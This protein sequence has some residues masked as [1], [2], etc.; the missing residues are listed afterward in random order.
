[1]KMHDMSLVASVEA[2]TVPEPRRLLVRPWEDPVLDHQGHDPRSSY[3]ET[4]WLPLLG[5]SATLLA[6][7]LASGLELD[8]GG[9]TLPADDAARSL[10]LGA[11]GGARS[12][13]NR[14][15]GRLA[16][17]RLVHLDAEDVVLARR[18]FPGLTRTQVA[19]LIPSLREAHEAWRAAELQAPALPALREQARTLALTLLQVGE[20]PEEVEAH[21]RKL[22]F[23][24][25]LAR[26][27]LAWALSHHH[28]TGPP[29][30][31]VR[32]QDRTDL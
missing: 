5:P 25:S 6:R 24:P 4:F 23:H 30:S 26:E 22:R 13:F 31:G 28:T 15:L 3:T 16:Q 1:M 20:T 10:G 12:P 29:A 14:T 19:K 8:P 18:R 9:F 32:Q 27:S 2:D 11:K 17:F 21:L 7:K